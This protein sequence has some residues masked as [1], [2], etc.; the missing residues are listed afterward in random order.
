M[1]KEDLTEKEIAVLGGLAS[2]GASFDEHCVTFDYISE[3]S[4]VPVKELPKIMK[5][6]R[7]KGLVE[8]YRGL[9]TEDCQVAGS[10][11]CL[12]SLGRELVE[13]LEL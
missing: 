3:E 7:S 2:C 13:K 1:K 6:L 9:V 4:K 12:S 10:G 5:S 11:Y 8:F